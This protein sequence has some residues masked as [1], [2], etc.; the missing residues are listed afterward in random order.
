MTDTTVQ[1]PS[2][3]TGT[4]VAK[5]PNSVT[6]KSY[7]PNVDA[8]TGAG[9]ANTNN[10][11]GTNYTVGTD[12]TLNQTSPGVISGSRKGGPIRRYA[13]GGGIPSKPTMKFAAG[14]ASP[15]S[16]TPTDTAAGGGA[17]VMNPNYVGPNLTGGWVG[18]TPYS[19][20]AP[21]QQAWADTTKGILG[22]ELNAA[23]QDAAY[24]GGGGNSMTGPN[25]TMQYW[26]Q[27][28]PM[29]DA[30]WPTAAA[31]AVPVAQPAPT[32]TTTNQPTPTVDPQNTA[33]TGIVGVPNTVTPT[34]T[35]PAT[36]TPTT[37]PAA[38]KPID[39]PAP[40]VTTIN[41]NPSTPLYKTPH[42][43]DPNDMAGGNTGGATTGE[44]DWANT[45]GTNY[46][47]GSNNF[48]AQN[49]PAQIAGF[50]RGGIPKRPTLGVRKGTN[51]Y[52]DGGG[53]SPSFVGM[54]PALGSGQQ[55]IPPYYFNPATY[56]PAGAPVG[57]GVSQTSVP[58]YGAGAIPSLPHD[59]GWRRGLRRR[60]R[61][62]GGYGLQ[63]PDGRPA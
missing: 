61:R 50:K 2:T 32:V 43:L 22:Q 60:R 16:F 14:G 55:Q 24:W 4:G 58:V 34:T 49:S 36:T 3:T 46:A 25:D 27:I 63:R 18:S 15:A 9:F 51:R 38:P 47:V 42:T 13:R 8:T 48:Q 6:A 19:A 23:H 39:Q 37:T 52:D 33:G 31:P 20:L 7:D 17:Y 30:I 40:N 41:G 5:V 59:E 45:G 44:G 21:N 35:T 11:G 26:N 62:C 12:D 10:A 28:T 29:P 54:P 53:V 1:D 56:S 57:K